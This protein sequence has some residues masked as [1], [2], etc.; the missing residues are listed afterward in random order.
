MRDLI[1]RR[2]MN[3]YLPVKSL[4]HY[5]NMYI[6]LFHGLVGQPTVNIAMTDVY[7]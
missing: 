6:L 7:Y 1:K 4:H 5:V 2:N 3:T